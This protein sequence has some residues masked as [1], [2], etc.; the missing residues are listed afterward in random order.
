MLSSRVHLLEATAAFDGTTPFTGTWKPE[1]NANWPSVNSTQ[2]TVGRISFSRQLRDGLSPALIIAR[3]WS[4]DAGYVMTSRTANSTEIADLK[5][6][7]DPL[8]IGLNTLMESRSLVSTRWCAP[9]L[10]GPTDAV[11]FAFTGAVRATVEYIMVEATSEQGLAFLQQVMLDVSATDED[12]SFMTITGTTTIPA[13]SGTLYAFV[14]APASTVITLPLVGD[15][16]QNSRLVLVRTGGTR[17]LVQASGAE[18][19]NGTASRQFEI[20]GLEAVEVRRASTGYSV[21]KP[22]LQATITAITNAVAGGIVDL[23]AFVSGTTSVQADYTAHGFARLPAL[24]LTPFDADMCLQR[25]VGGGT[26]Q[27]VLIPIAGDPLNGETDGRVFFGAK[28]AARIKRQLGGWCVTT[29]GGS[30]PQLKVTHAAN[31][32]LPLWGPGLLM[33]DC[34]QVAAQTETLPI[35][36]DPICVGAQVLFSALGAGGLTINGNGYLIRTAGAAATLVVTQNK[37]VLCTFSGTEW[38]ALIA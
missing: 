29:D 21:D 12:V 10:L 8:P 28:G 7:Y 27:L 19:L 16:G 31:T 25:L 37:N 26:S 23:P 35:S 9:I 11:T 33:V 38:V 15:Q 30:R 34:T 32:T 24:T 4:T 18:L 17:P 6:P 13:W 22:L 3:V 1:E 5:A 36:T 20:G 2:A 14:N